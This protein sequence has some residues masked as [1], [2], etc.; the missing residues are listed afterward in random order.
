MKP[1]S[2]PGVTGRKDVAG[3]SGVNKNHDE[4]ITYLLD[5][6]EQVLD[7]IN[8]LKADLDAERAK[9][10]QLSADS[11]QVNKTIEELKERTIEQK[12]R[13]D[14]LDKILPVG[15]KVYI[16]GAFDQTEKKKEIRTGIARLLV[17]LVHKKKFGQPLE[18]DYV[19]TTHVEGT[20]NVGGF[21]VEPEWATEIVS[22]RDM[23]GLAPRLCRRFR[24]THSKEFRIPTLSTHASVAW[25]DEDTTITEQSV[26]LARP[27]ITMKKLAAIATFSSEVMADSIPQI[28][29]FVVED[30]GRGFARE[31]DRVAFAGD[32]SGLSDPFNGIMFASGVAEVVAESGVNTYAE[33]TYNNLVDLMDEVDE[34]AAENGVWIFS[35]S[36]LNAIR[37][38][39]DTQGRPLFT[40]GDFTTQ[41]SADAPG[42][43]FGRPYYRSAVMPKQTDSGSQ[44]SKSF[45]I[46]GD[47]KF[48][49]LVDREDQMAIDFSDHAEFAKDVTT[50]RVKQRLGMGLL[51]GTG[52]GKLTTNAA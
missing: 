32:V 12:A 37:K 6:T 14:M 45:I 28:R 3:V 43:L 25:I 35:N 17:N 24:A 11:A 5:H 19:L 21:L 31:I 49:A 34:F 51:I 16:N 38:I 20:D 47:P 10:G 13:L 33:V 52:L 50:L 8:S 30:L 26:V 9:N 22:I 41:M 15:Q 4:A 18:K 1:V 29:D 27:S 48:Y 40:T 2:I 36:L 42:T 7:T 46:F 39:K 44:A 23:F